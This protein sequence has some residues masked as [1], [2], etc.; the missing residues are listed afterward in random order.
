MM[1]ANQGLGQD[2]DVRRSGLGLPHPSNLNT[3]GPI[4]GLL[5]VSITSAAALPW[6]LNSKHPQYSDGL[7]PHTGVSMFLCPERKR[8]S[9]Y[10][11]QAQIQRVHRAIVASAPTQHAG[12]PSGDKELTS[13]QWGGWGS[14]CEAG[15]QF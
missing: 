4:Q 8:S 10:T 6:G 5:T 2:L 7:L 3:L 9:K 11:E 13:P 14:D 15:S 1:T 12:G